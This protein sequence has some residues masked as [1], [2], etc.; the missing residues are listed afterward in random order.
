MA[1]RLTGSKKTNYAYAV[2]RVQARRSKLIPDSEYEKILKMDVSEITRYIEDSAYKTEVD[3][4]SNRFAGLDLL[5][6]ALTVNQERAHASVRE[7]VDGDGGQLLTLWLMRHLVDGLKSVLRGKQ[8]GASREELLKE[9]LLED[10][11]TYDLFQG[12]LG[13]DVQSPEDVATA[14]ERQGG[15]GVTWA[16]VLKQVPSGSG[17]AAYEDALDKAYYGHLLAELDGNK[18]KG[19]DL[20]HNF[21]RREIDARNLQNAARWVAN[22]QAG[23]FSPYVIPGGKACSI[24]AVVALS[25]TAD[26]AAFR[27][28]CMD[29]GLPE[30]LH[31]ALAESE[32]TGRLAPFQS[33]LNDWHLAE[34]DK[35]SHGAPLSLLPI[36]LYLTRKDREVV[37]LR[38]VARGKSAGL[39]EDRLRELMH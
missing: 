2:A 17:L 27:D 35:L 33:A 6:A 16:K 15:Y 24:S 31:A 25:Q 12:L 9:L 20:V 34:L 38:A 13:E 37:N 22:K 19:A 3:E 21:V 18:Q 29:L 23:D 39:S 36:L 32:T 4:L 5:E 26:L 14:L 7:M 11:D 10:L 30:S 28:K 8:G 1:L